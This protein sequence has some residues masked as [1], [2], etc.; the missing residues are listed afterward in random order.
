MDLRQLDV[1]ASADRH[2]D[3]VHVIAA[4]RGEDFHVVDARNDVV[5]LEGAVV[6][7]RDNAGVAARVGDHNDGARHSIA[8]AVVDAADDGLGL[9]CLNLDLDG[10][11][12]ARLDG[13]GAVDLVALDIHIRPALGQG[14]LE[15]EVSLAIREVLEV[16]LRGDKVAVRV[17]LD[18][19]LVVELLAGLRVGNALLHQLDVGASDR[20][21]GVIDQPAVN[22][23]RLCSRLVLVQ[24]N[25]RLAHLDRRHFG[26]L[27]LLH[28]H[29]LRL[30]IVEAVRR[31]D[32]HH[33]IA[34]LRQ[35]RH[36]EV[37]VLVDLDRVANLVAVL[38]LDDHGRQL[39]L[40]VLVLRRRK[41]VAL[42]VGDGADDAR[43]LRLRLGV[44]GRR[45]CGSRLR[46]RGGRLRRSRL[47][48]SRLRRSRLR[49]SRL[50][51]SRLR[52]SRL[53]RGRLR[54]RGRSRGG[55]LRRSRLR[56]RG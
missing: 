32:D 34:V 49:R 43:L 25:L 48:R 21:V 39:R 12:L 35:L 52:R 33:V 22:R 5:D 2:L 10:G 44:R 41:R 26:G 20:T 23:T 29:N 50:R 38:V 11:G 27:A 31:V 18:R 46:S 53:R 54:S 47:R 3:R 19:D 15:V 56:G 37:T 28:R 45:G 40:A 8:V 1:L 14:D 24:L 42:R 7:D 55:R 51:R 6:L 30:R 16:D 36:L 4:A 17:D 13:Y 9:R